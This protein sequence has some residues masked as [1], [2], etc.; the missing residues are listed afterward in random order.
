MNSVP[1][2]SYPANSDER[3]DMI[4]VFVSK[5]RLSMERHNNVNRTFLKKHIKSEEKRF[6]FVPIYK[7]E[8]QDRLK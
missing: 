8:K 5:D 2:E 1:G 4:C 7:P 6:R 3:G